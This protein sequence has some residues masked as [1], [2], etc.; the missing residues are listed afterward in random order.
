MSRTFAQKPV[1]K[2]RHAS[3]LQGVAGAWGAV[4]GAVSD[5]TGKGRILSLGVLALF[6]DPLGSQPVPFT[7]LVVIGGT[8]PFVGFLKGRLRDRSALGAQ[9]SW[10]WPVFAY[11]DGVAGVGF[12]NVFDAHLSNFRW[13]LL[14]LSAEL[15]IRTAAALG[16]SN[17]QFVIGI[18][19]EPFNQGLRL[20]SFSLAFGVT[21]AL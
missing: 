17:F 18:G 12:G 9:L 11:I 3:H 13:D 6:A 10:R 4:A 19:T 21:Y 5:V 16:P 20:T 7:D 2:N 14:R 1:P 15:G 8:E